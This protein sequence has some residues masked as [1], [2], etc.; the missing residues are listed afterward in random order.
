MCTFQTFA[1]DASNN[2]IAYQKSGVQ[3]SST[4]RVKERLTSHCLSRG[5]PFVDC[6]TLPPCRAQRMLGKLPSNRY[7][8]SSYKKL[9]KVGMLAIHESNPDPS[10]A[11]CAAVWRHCTKV[12]RNN[13][14]LVSIL[15][16]WGHIRS[17]LSST[18]R[19]LHGH[20]AL[21]SLNRL[22]VCNS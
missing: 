14:V 3:P 5:L 20:Q 15:A 4:N 9:P 22:L 10:V 11:Q 2:T 13:C 21:Q 16:C 7:S 17:G 12:N 8:L 18:S 6:T 1:V 19:L